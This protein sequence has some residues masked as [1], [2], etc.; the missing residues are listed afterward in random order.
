M[1][2]ADGYRLTITVASRHTPEVKARSDIRHHILSCFGI[3]RQFYARLALDDATSTQ[4][5]T[6]H[7]ARRAP[8]SRSAM[9]AP[10]PGGGDGRR[11]PNETLIREPNFSA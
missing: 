7:G 11:A 9:V 1:T 4:V 5:Q 10:W 2:V 8:L 6:R 3:D